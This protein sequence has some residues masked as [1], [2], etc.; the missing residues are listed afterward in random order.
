VAVSASSSSAAAATSLVGEKI[1]RSAAS[2]AKARGK[3][4]SRA[5]VGLLRAT[6]HSEGGDESEVH[7]FVVPRALAPTGGPDPTLDAGTPDSP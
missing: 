4:G 3:Q 6:K 5:A 7:A 1:G 2:R